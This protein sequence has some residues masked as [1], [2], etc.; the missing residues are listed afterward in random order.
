VKSLIWIEGTRSRNLFAALFLG[1]LLP[2][3]AGFAF[4][5]NWIISGMGKADVD[6]LTFIVTLDTDKKTFVASGPDVNSFFA[7]KKG[8]IHLGAIP[9]LGTQLSTADKK[10]VAFFTGLL[11]TATVGI[12]GDGRTE[13][14]TLFRWKLESR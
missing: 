11:G 5:G 7:T 10:E 6:G 1:V 8:N 2:L 13:K 14:G 3:H 9:E 12:M 4:A